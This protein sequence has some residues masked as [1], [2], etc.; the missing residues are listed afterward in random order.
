MLPFVESLVR[1][2]TLTTILDI[3]I[4]ALFFYWLFSL[5]RGTRAVTLVIGVSILLGVY[6][7]AQFLQLRLFTQILQAGAVVGLFALVV[8][9]QPELRRGLERI[10][11]VGTFGWLLAPTGQRAIE[12]IAAEV[13]KAAGVLSREGH[14]ALIVLERETGL[15]EIAE[16]GRDGARRPVERAAVHDLRPADLAPRWR[17]HHPRGP[18]PRRRRAPA[19]HR[20]DAVRAVRHP[21]PGGARDHRGHRRRG[22]GRLRGERADERRRAGTDRARAVRGAAPAC[23]P[24]CSRRRPLRQASAAAARVRSRA[25][26]RLRIR[27]TP[28]P[29]APGSPA[30]GA[31]GG[32]TPASATTPTTAASPTN[33]A[34]HDGPQAPAVPRTPRR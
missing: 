30:S 22:G 15:E 10:G 25:R 31:P 3:A 18:D 33:G 28:A 2:V 4:T 12:H 8:V 6:A 26:G 19:A 9:F 23:P 32:A 27:T 14:G 34:A 1:Q 16:T 11:R 29:A 13:A 20:D 21:A 5:I 24:R 7:L 17:R